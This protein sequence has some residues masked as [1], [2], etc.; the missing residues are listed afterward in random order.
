MSLKLSKMLYVI[1]LRRSKVAA[2]QPFLVGSGLEVGR[3]AIASLFWPIRNHTATFMRN[4]IPV[5][6]RPNTG[7]QNAYLIM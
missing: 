1:L 2:I 3:Y 4:T 5:F 6:R 7:H